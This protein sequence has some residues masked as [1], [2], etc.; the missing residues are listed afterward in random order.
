ME[1]VSG[2][3]ALPWNTLLPSRQAPRSSLC[4]KIALVPYFQRPKYQ[5]SLAQALSPIPQ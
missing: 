3:A 1:R 4:P 2:A 5:L